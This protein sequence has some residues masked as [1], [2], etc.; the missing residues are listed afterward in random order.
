VA[1]GTEPTRVRGSFRNPLTLVGAA[2]VLVSLANIV[3][4]LLADILAVRAKPYFGVFAYMVFPAILILGL[5]LVPAGMFLARWQRRRRAAGEIPLF[6]RIDLNL[7]S[8]RAAFGLF[9][10]FTAFFLVLSTVGSYQT[11]TR[12]GE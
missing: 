11:R 5:L 9:L 2:L 3:F 12:R 8:H 10:G 1:S 4:L 7:P 6:P